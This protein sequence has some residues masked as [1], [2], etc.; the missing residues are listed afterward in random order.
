MA[1]TVEPKVLI[2]DDD[3]LIL[4]IYARKFSDEH[5]S[6]H[7]IGDRQATPEYIAAYGPSLIL[8]DIAMPHKSGL[9]ILKELKENPT[10]KNINVVLLT[11]NANNDAVKQGLSLGAD[12]YILKVL[13]IPSEVV[14][15]AKTFL[16]NR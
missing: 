7:C 3:P 1:T 10:T 4:D 5:I 12:D 9:A 2:I 13:H 11:N 14:Q 8:L 6:V 15:K 16:K